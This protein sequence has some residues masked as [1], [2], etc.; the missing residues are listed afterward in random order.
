MA[1]EIGL[2][3]LTLVTFF[4]AEGAAK[5]SPQPNQNMCNVHCDRVL[6][7]LDETVKCIKIMYA[8]SGNSWQPWITYPYC[9]K[10]DMTKF[11][12][13]CDLEHT[14]GGNHTEHDVPHRH[15]KNRVKTCRHKKGHAKRGH[16]AKGHH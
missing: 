10:E 4:A 12:K 5:E 9:Q 3:A 16:H 8:K 14:Q 2:V 1:R 15:P 11:T 7:D 13:G 6:N